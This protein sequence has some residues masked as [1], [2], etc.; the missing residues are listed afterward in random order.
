MFF[1]GLVGLR[2]G[3]MGHGFSAELPGFGF[4]I[5]PFGFCG[6]GMHVDF[7]QT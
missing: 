2:R 7:L 4:F 6:F 1:F 3:L 5:V